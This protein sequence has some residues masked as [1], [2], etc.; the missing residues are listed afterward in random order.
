[1]TR[2]CT[3]FFNGGGMARLLEQV[4]NHILQ[5]QVTDSFK[6]LPT[7]GRSN[8]KAIATEPTRIP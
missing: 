6:P 3:G 7:R 4:L 1:M 5:A 2:F 8:A